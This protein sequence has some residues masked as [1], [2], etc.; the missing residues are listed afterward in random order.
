[1]RPIIKGAEPAEFAAW[2]KRRA[3]HKQP[4]WDSTE[5][6]WLKAKSQV[7]E[8]LLNEQ[9][10]VCCYCEQR[11][12]YSNAHI[13]HLESRHTAPKRVFDHANL[14]ASCTK[15]SHCGSLKGS[16]AL[17]VH[18][19]MPDCR[20]HFV[21]TSNGNVRP[22]DNP[23]RRSVA[24]EAITVLGLGISTL[25]AQRKSAITGFT[26]ALNGM[27]PEQAR[28]ALSRIDTRDEQGQNRPFASAI[29]SVFSPRP[30]THATPNTSGA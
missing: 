7:K 15:K 9:G 30:P 11:I 8:A 18:P 10:F 20:E 3:T 25:N 22:T 12:E 4:P 19:L 24:E 23:A 27:D 14:L 29:L 21:F 26:Q 5:E 6:D 13:E 28:E 1:M 16:K 17:R 2:K